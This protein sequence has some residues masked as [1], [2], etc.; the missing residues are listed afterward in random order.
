MPLVLRSRARHFQEND[1]AADLQGQ[2]LQSQ[3]HDRQTLELT[4]FAGVTEKIVNLPT[5]TYL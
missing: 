2:H 4:V 1:Q 5:M 3:G